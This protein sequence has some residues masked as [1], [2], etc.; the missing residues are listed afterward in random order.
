MISGSLR[1]SLDDKRTQ[2]VVRGVR[3]VNPTDPN[4]MIFQ[5]PFVVLQSKDI[6]KYG[7]L[8]ERV[9]L[10]TSM[11]ST[12]GSEAKKRAQEEFQVHGDLDRV[13][14]FEVPGHPLLRAGHHVWVGDP[15]G[16]GLNAWL[17]V[18]RITHTVVGSTYR[19]TLDVSPYIKPQ[20]VD[21]LTSTNMTG[22]DISRTP[23]YGAGPA[24]AGAPAV[25]GWDTRKPG[26]NTGVDN[27]NAES[28]N[29]FLSN[30]G[31][32]GRSPLEGYGAV[33]VTASRNK[34]DPRL[35]VA[36]AGAETSFGT[37][38][39]GPRYFNAWGLGPGNHYSSWKAG[40]EAAVYNLTRPGGYYA[41]KNTILSIWKT[42]A[43][44][45]AAND[46]QGLNANW[47]QNV[48]RFMEDMGYGG[49]LSGVV[50]WAP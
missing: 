38:G 31:I 4:S 41:G 2:I 21:V 10:T 14:T 43:P 46:P 50:K 39:G 6:T 23:V 32:Q 36:I 35:I 25:P 28:I 26:P 3:R 27:A 13:G 47:P 18:S 8:V 33:I 48:L 45:G 44:A 16:T 7:P 42:W 30:P 24:P 17:T 29:K 15:K 5:F 19:M 20:K 11:A 34:V 49:G 1:E 9:D 22:G 37:A 12:S 40:I